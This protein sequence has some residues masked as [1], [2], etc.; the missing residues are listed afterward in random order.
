MRFADVDLVAVVGRLDDQ[1]RSPT[2]RHAFAVEA[3]AGDRV[4]GRWDADRLEQVVGHLLSTAIRYSPD[5]GSITIT[6]GRDTDTAGAWAVLAV[7]DEGLGIPAADLP[8]VFERF[9]RGSNVAGR[10]PGLGIGLAGARAIVEQ[11]GG[12]LG[13]E[14]QEGAG[15]RFTVRLPLP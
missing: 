3:T 7:Q 5:G 13:V 14:S 12:T 8:Q 4:V 6:L 9:H 2:V 15:S 11:H 10:I 1:S